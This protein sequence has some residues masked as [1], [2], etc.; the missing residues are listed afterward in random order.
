MKSRRLLVSAYSVVL[1]AYPIAARADKPAAPGHAK[2]G[3]S[4]KAQPGKSGEAAMVAKEEAAVHQQYRSRIEKLHDELSAGKIT[5]EQFKDE[6]TKLHA[7]F[8]ERAQDE[9]NEVKKRWGA[10]VRR[11]DVYD[12]LKNHARR[13]AYLDRAVVVVEQD[14]S[15][16]P[17]AQLMTRIKDLREQ[18]NA[19]HEAAMKRFA[20]SA[21]SGQPATP[22][23]A[24]SA[25]GGG[26]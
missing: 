13:I 21:G 25:S 20:S 9:G 12:E 17:R 23:P 2:P 22:G 7:T 6:L 14:V 3:S 16:P 24:T 26:K 19:R 8:A 10:L 11:A 18:E 4:A 5:R 1:L 15:E